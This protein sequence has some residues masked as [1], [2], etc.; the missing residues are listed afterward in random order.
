VRAPG[1][2]PAAASWRGALRSICDQIS[3]LGLKG[4][5]VDA[6]LNGAGY[7]DQATWVGKQADCEINC[8][9]EWQSKIAGH[10]PDQGNVLE[11]A[12]ADPTRDALLG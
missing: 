4:G 3:E 10:P 12:L 5:P 7:L 8:A 11:S 6:K 2:P 9:G 1:W